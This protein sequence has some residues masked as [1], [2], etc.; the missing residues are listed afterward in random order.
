MNILRSDAEF[1]SFKVAFQKYSL[2]TEGNNCAAK[3]PPRNKLNPNYVIEMRTI[4][5]E[6]MKIKCHLEG[7]N[8]KCPATL[9]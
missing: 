4:S 5:A 1:Q 8:E 6:Q 9:V 3:N 7:F 2:T